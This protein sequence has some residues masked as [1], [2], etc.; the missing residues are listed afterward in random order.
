MSRDSQSS[1]NGMPPVLSPDMLLFRRRLLTFLLSPLLLCVPWLPF[2]LLYGQQFLENAKGPT[3]QTQIDRAFAQAVSRDYDMLFLGN[4]RIYRGLNPDRFAVSS[5]NFGHNDDTYN[6]VFYKL[7]W[8]R[9]QGVSFRYLVLGVDF[10]QFSY[11]SR[12]RNQAYGKYLGE[13]Y[14]ADYEPQ[15]WADV[16]LKIRLITRGLNPKYMFLPN[17]GRTFLRDNGQYVKPGEAS[18]TDT[19][20]RSATR[21]PLQVAYF[22]KVLE[23]CRKHKVK[24]FLCMLPVRPEERN[25]YREGEI[26]D[27]MQFIRGYLDSDVALIDYTLDPEYS[28]ADYTDITHFNESAAERFSTQLNQDLLSRIHDFSDQRN[29][30]VWPVSSQ[31]VHK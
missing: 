17:D 20:V 10:F 8:L 22:E 30:T 13:D 26:D 15:P 14:L 6:H 9:D 25:C 3:Y 21:L 4:S 5:Y 1:N 18:P 7:K 19:A 27:F 12:Q 29:R 28:L 23:D 16:G 31:K 11:M 2:G 24:V